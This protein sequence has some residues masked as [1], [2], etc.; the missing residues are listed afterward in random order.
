MSWHISG[1]LQEFL[2]SAGEFLRSRPVENTI[3]LTLA[4]S[5]RVRGPHAFGPDDPIFGWWT[6][7]DGKVEG[8]CL[9]T[10]PWPVLLTALPAGAAAELARTFAGRPLSGVNGR[11]ADAEEFAAAWPQPF[12]PGMQTRLFRLAEL[13][14]PDPSPPGRARLATA[15]DRPLL[16]EWIQE[17]HAEI[18]E[19]RADFAV[20]VDDRLSFGGWWLWEVD[21]TPVAL[22]GR[23]RPE[24]RMVRVIAVYTPPGRR[25]RGF[26]GAATVAVTR[27][28][29]DTGATDVVLFTD[30]ANRTSNALYQRLGYRPVEDRSVL[31]FES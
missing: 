11:S 17:F 28:A 8:A 18:G 14:P 13:T 15:D 16:L 20:L 23:T 2:D 7:G 24:A 1:D 4:D 27:A 29:L 5:L 19:P 12:H 22:A 26:G 9:Q 21:G 6:T 31:E 10:P 3:P 30:I 25:A